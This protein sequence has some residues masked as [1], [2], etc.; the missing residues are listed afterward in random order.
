MRVEI[1]QPLLTAT[2]G[3]LVC[4]AAHA[5]ILIGQ[6]AGLSGPTAA[7]MKEINDGANLYFEAVNRQGGVQ[8][9]PI[10]LISVD[11]K[12]D[13]KLAAQNAQELADKNV[14]ALFLSRGTQQTEAL[15][16]VLAKNEMALIGPSSGAMSLHEPVNRFVYN[17]RA[18]YQNEASK[19][20]GLLHAT[21]INKIAVIYRDDGFGK[22]GLAGAQKGFV[23]AGLEPLFV[24]KVDRS[25]ADFAA[26]I[27]KARA[28]NPQAVLILE[29][30][31]TVARAVAE[32]RAA[33]LTSQV[34]TLSNCA[35]KGFIEALGPHARGVIVTQV[36]P[37][38]RARGVP[39]VAEL[40]K[41]AQARQVEV[42]PATLEGFA[43]AKVLV[44]ALRRIKGPP[45]RKA[46]MAALDSMS[47]Y[48][49]GGL[50]LSFSPTDHTGLSF[51]DLSIVDVSGK[52]RR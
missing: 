19:G 18:P 35:S 7:A 32:L 25:K 4:A 22:D 6:T 16:P 34:I 9:L 51:A 24:E 36:F 42:S 1:K 46:L 43:A 17:V 11:D 27:A 12:F 8:G 30:P 41:L 40:Q 21:G 28:L 15:L 31:A 10:R 52:F 33:G 37:G 13:A 3:L 5:E 20:I 45:R 44:E 49:L 47:N 23:A 50:P 29:A 26:S 39:M 2:I 14:L 38:E 48:D